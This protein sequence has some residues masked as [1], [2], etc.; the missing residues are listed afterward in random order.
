MRIS[1]WSSDVCSSDLGRPALQRGCGQRACP[2]AGHHRDRKGLE[3][4]ERAGELALEAAALQVR[5]HQRP[6]AHA[7]LDDRDVGFL[8]DRA[9]QAR[10]GLLADRSE[11]HTSELKTLMRISYAVFCVKKNKHKQKRNHT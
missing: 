2:M 6:L 5:H 9:Q 8:E 10:G 7:R 11:E 1:D 3:Q 4:E